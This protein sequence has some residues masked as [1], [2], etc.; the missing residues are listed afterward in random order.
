MEGAELATCLPGEHRWGSSVVQQWGARLGCRLSRV[1][2]Q[3][4]ATRFT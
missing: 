1:W 2:M 4:K 3:G